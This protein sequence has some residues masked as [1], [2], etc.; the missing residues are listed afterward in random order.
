MT[1]KFTDISIIALQCNKLQIQGDLATMELEYTYKAF[2]LDT[3]Q[4]YTKTLVRGITLAKE[5][6]N[7]KITQY[8]RIRE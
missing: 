1:Q 6:G 8:V 7:W 5:S 4:E 2:N 3:L